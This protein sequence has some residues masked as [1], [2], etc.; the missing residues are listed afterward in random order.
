MTKRRQEQTECLKYLK[1]V[2]HL[3]DVSRSRR[4]WKW[5]AEVASWQC[6]PARTSEPT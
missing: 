1:D 5:K 4:R 2:L 6:S 3:T